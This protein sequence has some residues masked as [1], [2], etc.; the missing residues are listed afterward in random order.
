[1]STAYLIAVIDSTSNPP[2]IA[3]VSILSERWQTATLRHSPT[4]CYVNLWESSGKDWEEARANLREEIEGPRGG[5]E[6]ARGGHPLAGEFF[7]DPARHA[8][9]G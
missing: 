4:R 9:A 1:M 6:G 2:Q 3:G 5:H 8:P 7:Q